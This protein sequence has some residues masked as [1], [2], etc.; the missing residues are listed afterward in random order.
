MTKILN[1][2]L[3]AVGKI[4]VIIAQALLVVAQI[5]L[6]V[7]MAAT[8]IAALGYFPENMSVEGIDELPSGAMW[9]AALIMALLL[10]SLGL[11]YGAVTRLGAII[12][13]VRLGDPFLR[14]NADRLASMAWRALAVQGIGFVC[15]L[16]GAWLEKT[17][18]EPDVFQ[19]DFE[20]SFAGVALAVILFILARV[21]RQGTAMRAELEGTV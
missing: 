18:A 8:I 11:I 17:Y 1:D 14:V 12:D 9:L 15:G 2:P 4:G 19:L 21:F 5:A 20:V 10:V 7:A 13:T 16:L 3:L 6:G